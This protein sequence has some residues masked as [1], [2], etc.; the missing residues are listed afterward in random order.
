MVSIH[1]WWKVGSE[2]ENTFPRQDGPKLGPKI[3]AANLCGKVHKIRLKSRGACFGYIEQKTY[4]L[5]GEEY[6]K[7]LQKWSN[8]QHETLQH[9]QG[10]QDFGKSPKGVLTHIWSLFNSDGHTWCNYLFTWKQGKLSWCTFTLFKCL[11]NT[12][13]TISFEINIYCFDKKMQQGLYQ[14]CYV[15][16]I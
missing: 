8:Q 10:M 5:Q 3:I 6:L 11:Q 1:N 7:N 4:W 2:Q 16:V 13:L 14:S 12:L 15:S 9:P